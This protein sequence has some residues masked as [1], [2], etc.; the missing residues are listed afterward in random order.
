MIAV[1]DVGLGV[2][3]CEFH[4]LDLQVDAVR[5]IDWQRSHVEVL[6]DSEGDQRD[7]ALAVGR[8]LVH[9]VPPVSTGDG[10]DPV[11][12]MRGEVAGPHGST[13][14]GRVGYEPGR[15]FAAVERLAVG[16]RN[17]LQRCGMVGQCD[18]LTRPRC[19]PAGHEGLG[20]SGLRFK[21]RHLSSPLLGDGR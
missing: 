14:G 15:Q 17:G 20:E 19:S 21:E 5:G 8:Y 18:Q 12:A 6:K 4:R 7:D 2:G 9:G 3:E 16:C 1:G 10:A 11:G 13:V